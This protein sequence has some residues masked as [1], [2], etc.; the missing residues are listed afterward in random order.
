MPRPRSVMRK[1]REVL[2][3]TFAEGLS[4]RLAG[5]AAGMPTMTRASSVT[6]SSWSC[7]WKM[8]GRARSTDQLGTCLLHQCL[9]LRPRRNLVTPHA[10]G[11]HPRQVPPHRIDNGHVRLQVGGQATPG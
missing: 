7:S 4:R 6:S 1:I 3:L 2:R 5:I 9:Q 11:G 8:A 10:G